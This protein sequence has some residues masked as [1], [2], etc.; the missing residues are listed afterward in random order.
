VKQSGQREHEHYKRNHGSD[1]LKRDRARV[2]QQVM[3]L[4]TVKN[5]PAQLADSR[6]NL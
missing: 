5:R 6:T 4:E 3:L 2:R 1:D